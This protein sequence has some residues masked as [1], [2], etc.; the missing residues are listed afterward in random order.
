MITVKINGI[1]VE[2][3]RPMNVIEAA[4]KVGIHVPH[5]CYHKELTLYAGCRICMVEVKG[6]PKAVAGCT[7]I[8]T[9]GMEVVTESEKLTKARRGILEL[10]LAHHP[11]DCPKCDKGG[12]CLLQDYAFKYGA[13]RSRFIEK[14]RKIPVNY[15]NPLIERNMERCVSCKRC[16][17]ICAEVQGDHVLYDMNRGSRVIFGSFMGREEECVHCGHCV[18]NCPVGAIQSRLTKHKIRPWYVEREADTVC[19]YCGNGCLLTLQSREGEIVRA[20][21][22]ETYSRGSNRGRLCV[23]G[24]YGLDFPNH[25]ERITKPLV[26]RNGAFVQCGWDEAIGFVA[27]KLSEIKSASG[28]D[29]IGALTGGRNTNEEAYLLQKFMR[30]VIGT[31]N[32]DNSARMGHINA[33][34][35]IEAALGIPAMTG[36]I[37][38]IARADA[39][40]MVG[41]DA[42]SDNPITGLAVKAA[43]QKNRAKLIVADFAKNRMDRHASMRLTYRPGTALDLIN[44]LINAVFAHSMDNLELGEKHKELFESIK[45]GVAAYTPDAVSG[46]TGVGAESIVAAAKAFGMAETAAIIFG[47]GVTSE[48]GGYAA[49]VALSYLSLVTGN[50]GKPGGGVNPMAPKANEQGACDM[51]ALPDRLPGYARV[52]SEDARK[53]CAGVW[54]KKLPDTPGL[55]AMEM[56]SSA[57]AGKLQALY[58]MGANPAFELPDKG[59]FEAA[60]GKLKLLVVQDMFMTETARLADVILPAASFAEKQG[61]FTNSERRVQM[62]RPVIASPGDCLPDGEIIAMVSGKMGFQMESAPARVMDEAASVADIYSGLNYNVLSGDGLQWPYDADA[63]KGTPTLFAGGVNPGPYAKPVEA[64]AAGEAPVSEGFTFTLDSAVSLYHSGSMTRRAHGPNMVVGAPFA[65]LN[66]ADA[67]GL[68]IKDGGSVVVKSSTGSLKLPVK[69]DEGVPAGTVHVPNHFEG[70]GTNGLIGTALDPANK[71]PN[72]RH[73]PVAIE[74]G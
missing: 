60:A 32:I 19:P 56:V 28:P 45:S 27:A 39:V 21:A 58:V 74:K 68:S 55:T 9:D 8:M 70:H 25:K 17:R 64:E 38:D 1:S 22:D 3:E 10:Q 67:A 46:K 4:K 34:T 49:S 72:G 53:K 65:S 5:F 52:S 33:I 73:W 2:L 35:G 16:V 69:L 44:G 59:A 66:P 62:V 29:S 31:N 50:A 6:R 26:K 63:G 18:S 61:T 47:R 30:A 20:V 43:V 42:S 14:K 15:N 7:T 11:L 36:R 51:G 57:N 54:G 12:E 40:L 37:Q 23:R 71:V 13:D 48:L 24:R 41:T